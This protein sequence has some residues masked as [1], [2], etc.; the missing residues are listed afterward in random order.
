MQHLKRHEMN[1]KRKLLLVDD[2]FESRQLLDFI[3]SREYSVIHAENGKQALE[4]LKENSDSVSLV[5]LDLHMPVMDG[6]ELLTILHEDQHL[7][8]IPVIVLTDKRDSE[9]KGLEL[10]AV[11][12]ITKPYSIPD[13]ILARIKSALKYS[14]DEFII[15]ETETDQL[16]GL[17]TKAYFLHY[18]KQHDIYFPDMSMDAVVIEIS[19]FQLLNELYGRAYGDRVLSC[20]GDM[21]KTLVLSIGSDA[22]ACRSESDRFELYIPHREDHDLLT[23]N[24]AELVYAELGNRRLDIRVGIYSNV[25]LDIPLEQRFDR[26]VIASNNIKKHR[27]SSYGFYDIETHA[28][29]LLTERLVLEL[30]E[31]IAERQ[32]IVYYQPKYDIRGKNPV[33]TSAEALVRW[34]HPEMGM[35]SPGLFVPAFEEHGLIPKLDRYVWRDVCEQIYNWKNKYGECIPVSLNVSRVDLFDPMLKSDLMDMLTEFQL[36]PDDISL[37]ITESAYTD[38]SEEIIKAV[39]EL[40]NSGFRIEMDDFGTGYSSLNMLASMPIDALKLDMRFVHDIRSSKKDY[41][42]VKMVIDISKLLKIPVIAEG[43][44]DEDQYHL[45]KKAGCDIIQGYY[46]SKPVKA[47]DLEIKFAEV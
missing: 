36:K 42:L 18:A 44:E 23:Y 28:K 15:R 43:V 38:N 3:V 7:K 26:A 47:E 21:L 14:E 46:F 17:Y 33:L 30:D 16:T 10:G 9:L 25:S 37:E 29:E 20:V 45:L 32:F 22:L 19:R 4:I 8:R 1:I 11:D 27:Y 41:R 40:R 2:E 12:F 34:D 24:C 5:L 39:N 6:F 31:A 13:I 35:V